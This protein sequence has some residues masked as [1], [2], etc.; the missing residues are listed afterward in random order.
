MA[1]RAS[2]GV[3]VRRAIPA[4]TL[5]NPLDPSASAPE[6]RTIHWGGKEG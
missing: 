2:R 3:I 6:N 5:G 1:Q 4:A